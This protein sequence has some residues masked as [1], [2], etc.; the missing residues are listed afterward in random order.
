MNQSLKNR[1]IHPDYM[2]SPAGLLIYGIVGVEVVA[3]A[4]FII[5]WL[6]GIL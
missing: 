3:G 6:L 1:E 2:V 5:A 4:S